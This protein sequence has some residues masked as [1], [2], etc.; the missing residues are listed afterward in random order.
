[1]TWEKMDS[2]P[3]DGLFRLYG[4]KVKNKNGH[5]WFEVFYLQID[6]CTGELF[7]TNGD[8]FSVWVLSDFEVWCNAPQPLEIKCNACK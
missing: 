3:A 2:E 8:K 4:L 1:M 6:N 5:S 7:E